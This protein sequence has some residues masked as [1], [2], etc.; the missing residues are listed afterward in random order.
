MAIVTVI[1]KI[2]HEY[3]YDNDHDFSGPVLLSNAAEL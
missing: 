3:D 2:D 1:V